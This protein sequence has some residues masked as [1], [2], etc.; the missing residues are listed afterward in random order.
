MAPLKADDGTSAEFDRHFL[1]KSFQRVMMKCSVKSETYKDENRVKCNCSSLTP[2][3]FVSEARSL[4]A[5][6]KQMQG[7]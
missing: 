2:L 5:E 7:R 1:N 6:I 3:D 4:L